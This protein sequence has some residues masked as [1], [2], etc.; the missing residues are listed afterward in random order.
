MNA[1]GGSIPSGC[2]F[3]QAKVDRTPAY[4]RL[5]RKR[6]KAGRPMKKQ[7]KQHWLK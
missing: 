3:P 6:T 5:F 2:S 7:A 1:K 4:D